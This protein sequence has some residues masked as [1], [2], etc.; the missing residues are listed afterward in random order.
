[1]RCGLY[2]AASL[3]AAMSAGCTA[4]LSETPDSTKI[5]VESP[6]VDVGEGPVDLDPGTDDDI[7]VDTPAPGDQ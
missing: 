4:E 1:M 6:D 2:V 7:D 3:F 5:K